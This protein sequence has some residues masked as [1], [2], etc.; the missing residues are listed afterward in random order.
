M[1]TIHLLHPHMAIHMP[2]P[3]HWV[4][5]HQVAIAWLIVGVLLLV[6]LGV[7]LSSYHFGETSGI[8]KG[9]LMYPQYPGY[10]FYQHY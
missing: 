1:R 2:H 4:H 6:I 5:K 8:G 10:P 7:V 9:S 3:E